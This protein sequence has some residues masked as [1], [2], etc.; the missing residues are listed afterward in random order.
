MF[1]VGWCSN[2]NTLADGAGDLA[3]IGHQDS[4]FLLSED[5]GLEV[6]GHVGCTTIRLGLNTVVRPG[7]QESVYEGVFEVM[8][9]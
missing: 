2:W 5:N 8:C 3:S 9:G 7:E 1:K 4:V 6:Q